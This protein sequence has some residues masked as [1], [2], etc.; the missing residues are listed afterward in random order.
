[1]NIDTPGR[2]TLGSHVDAAVKQDASN[3]KLRSVLGQLGRAIL[4]SVPLANGA[5]S[6][7][8]RVFSGIT[9]PCNSM[10]VHLESTTEHIINAELCKQFTMI[11]HDTL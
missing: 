8:L 9:M 1:M 3:R 5:R 6:V 10:E 11:I 2:L 7:T 4:S